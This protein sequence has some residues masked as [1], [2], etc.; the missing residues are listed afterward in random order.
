MTA[1][2]K[3]LV[4][5]RF[6]DDEQFVK[7]EQ[8]KFSVTAAANPGCTSPVGTNPNAQSIVCE[9]ACDWA[10]KARPFAR[11]RM[12]NTRGQLLWQWQA[13]ART[14]HLELLSVPSQRD[15]SD[16]HDGCLSPDQKYL[17]VTSYL[18]DAGG[19]AVPA[20]SLAGY[21]IVKLAPG[22]TAV[23]VTGKKTGEAFGHKRFTRFIAW[24][25]GDPHTVIFDVTRP[26]KND[27]EVID[28]G[29]PN[30]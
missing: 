16:G 24:K 7:R 25:A 28:E 3:V 8:E 30:R 27:I 29:V 11:A 23:K 4:L 15:G 18:M 21:A 12:K 5:D 13:R 14:E 17:A 1:E 6:V 26:E 22:L 19:D 10:S 2:K 9:Q 20:Q